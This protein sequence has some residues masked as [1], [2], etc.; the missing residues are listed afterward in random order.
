VTLRWKAGL[1]SGTLCFSSIGRAFAADADAP[2]RTNSEQNTAATPTAPQFSPPL[3]P[4]PIEAPPQDPPQAPAPAPVPSNTTTSA[5]ADV[6]ASKDEVKELR[7]ELERL[8][9]AFDMSRSTTDTTETYQR[10]IEL[11]GFMDMGFQKLWTSEHAATLGTG[12]T[13]AG[14]FALGNINLYIDAN[15]TQNWR[16]LTELRFTNYPN[17]A[18]ESAGFPALGQSEQRTS[19]TVYD[20]NSPDPG[21]NQVNWGGIVLE[22]AWIQG[23]VTD[24]FGVRVG[25]WRTPFGIWNIDHGTPTLIGLTPPQ[26]TGGRFY[27]QHQ[28]GVQALGQVTS[29]AWTFNYTAYISNGKTAGTLDPTDEK[30]FGLRLSAKTMR[31]FPMAFGLAGYTG[32][33]SQK[34][35]NAVP[36]GMLYVSLDEVV[37]YRQWDVGADASLDINSFRFRTELAVERIDYDKGKLD[38]EFGI[39]GMYWP[40]RMMW[41]W[42]TIAANQL[43]WLGLE[44]YLSCE[45]YRFPTVLSDAIVVPGVGL[46]VHFNT[47]VQLKTQFTRVHFFDFDGAHDRSY[48]DMSML[49]TRLVIAY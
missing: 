6:P 45:L 42:Y 20:V 35:L 36:P 46:N 10:A 33:Y 8:R 14:T 49:A 19:T 27:P 12:P 16:A 7:S 21:W 9:A 40:N 39:P 23:T 13:R 44:P 1:V 29:Q 25:Y 41:G 32:R 18:L 22:Q 38:P 34:V 48:Q 43:P 47:E 24:G 15:P 28:L 26:F 37:A 3:T 30:A 5:S 2:V 17:G 31:P 4:G 11:Y